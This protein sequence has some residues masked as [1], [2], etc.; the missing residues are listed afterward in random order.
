MYFVDAIGNTRP[1]QETALSAPPM[2]GADSALARDSVFEEDRGS[3]EARQ[4][5]EQSAAHE[6]Q[7]CK[8]CI[9]HYHGLCKKG[10]ECNQCHLRHNARQLRRA[11]PSRLKR[12]SLRGRLAARDAGAGEGASSSAYLG[13]DPSPRAGHSTEPFATG[14]RSA[15]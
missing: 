9:F 5:Q 2:P 11:Q 8:P 3:E 7:M 15:A 4:S 1:A 12:E 13:S 6:A 10:E 14:A